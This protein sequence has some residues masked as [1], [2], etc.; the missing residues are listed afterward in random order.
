MHLLF[1]DE[2]G[3]PAK[4]A[5]DRPEYFVIAGLAI[6]HRTWMPLH[7]R[8]HGL[9]VAWRYRGEIKWRYFSPSNDD[10]A[11]PMS[12]WTFERRCDFRTQV[13]RMLRDSNDA[14][15]IA[16]VSQAGPAFGLPIVRNQDDL[17]FRTYKPLTERFQYFLQER[18]R[19]NGETEFG[20]IIADQRGSG[21]DQRLRAQHQRLTNTDAEFTSTY[22]NLIEGLFLTESHMS[23]GIQLADMVAGAIWRRFE[24]EDTRSFDEIAPLLRRCQRTGRVDGFGICRFPKAQWNGLLIE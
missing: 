1:L 5:D 11:N 2:S 20:M 3:T 22:S 21:A 6:P 16:C 13:F 19:R 7:R 23:T 17:Y 9:K 8:L 15:V 12:D 18:S 10:E 14:T 4:H 24:C